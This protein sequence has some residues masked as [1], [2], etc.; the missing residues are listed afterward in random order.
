M[1]RSIVKLWR[2]I[3]LTEEDELLKYSYVRQPENLKRVN[4][5]VAEPKR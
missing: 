5:T 4:Q 1:F 2:R 3:L